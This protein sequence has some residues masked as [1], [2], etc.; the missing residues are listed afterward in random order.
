MD[1]AHR[2]PQLRCQNPARCR[3][4]VLVQLLRQRLSL[5]RAIENDGDCAF[6]LLTSVGLNRRRY[7]VLNID[8]IGFDLVALH[9]T[10]LVNQIHVVVVCW[11]HV[12]ADDLRRSS[13]VAQYPDHDLPLL[14][15]RQ[16]PWC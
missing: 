4:V 14:T 6:R 1:S 16:P 15:R 9:A 8:F 5:R 3:D 7:L 11:T 2:W 13:P 10:P 12:D